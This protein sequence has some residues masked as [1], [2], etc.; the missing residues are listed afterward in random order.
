MCLFN[1]A[2]FSVLARQSVLV[3]NRV[4]LWRG[5][6][7]LLLVWVMHRA[8]FGSTADINTISFDADRQRLEA[9]IRYELDL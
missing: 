9:F 5:E 6:E 2:G 4:M 8:Y 7:A 1:C 3:C